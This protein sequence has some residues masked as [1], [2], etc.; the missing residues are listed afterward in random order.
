MHV[1][2]LDQN[3]QLVCFIF[4]F[5]YMTFDFVSQFLYEIQFWYVSKLQG[6]QSTTCLGL[7]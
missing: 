3:K 4:L 2:I 5:C 1:G 6:G 7:V